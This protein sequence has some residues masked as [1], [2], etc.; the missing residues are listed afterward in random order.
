MIKDNRFSLEE[1]YGG[2]YSEE[3]VIECQ[4]V[5]NNTFYMIGE[6]NPSILDAGYIILKDGRFIKVYQ[7]QEHDSVFSYFY[8]LYLELPFLREMS[9]GTA[10]KE[11]NKLGFPVYFGV[12]SRYLSEIETKGFPLNEVSDDIKAFEKPG[13]IFVLSLPKDESGFILTE[14]Q[15]RSIQKLLKSYEEV[16][17]KVGFSSN[18]VV[19][20]IEE[21]LEL[22]QDEVFK[23]I[24]DNRE[25]K[26]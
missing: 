25:R 6:D 2:Y 14:D 21:S 18:L 11:L 9:S 23:I 22:S 26:I 5:K 16:H 17:S 15:K 24:N 3:K 10:A 19:G 13:G 8:T 1:I 7:S 20:N 12:K 4:T